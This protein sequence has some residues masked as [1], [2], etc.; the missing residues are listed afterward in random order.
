MADRN[1][2]GPGNICPPRLSSYG[3]DL[4]HGPKGQRRPTRKAYSL[5]DQKDEN[6]AVHGVAFR[7]SVTIERFIPSDVKSRVTSAGAV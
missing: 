6:A 3:A 2:T 4:E 1:D 5:R 7:E